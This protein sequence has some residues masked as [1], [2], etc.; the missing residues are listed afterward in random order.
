MRTRI[1]A[2]LANWRQWS[3]RRNE[4]SSL[5][6]ATNCQIVC[7]QERVKSI[8]SRELNESHAQELRPAPSARG[9]VRLQAALRFQIAALA[10]DPSCRLQSVCHFEQ[11]RR[12]ELISIRPMAIAFGPFS[13][14]LELEGQHTASSG[15]EP[16]NARGFDPLR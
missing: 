5:W 6:P 7:R 12:E 16:I 13:A 2:A 10:F 8:I 3:E 11:V 14:L 4:S 9:R 1:F 15:M